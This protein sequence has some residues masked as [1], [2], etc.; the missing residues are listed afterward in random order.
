MRTNHPQAAGGELL[1]GQP[2]QDDAAKILNILDTIYLPKTLLN[3]T[4]MSVNNPR[5]TRLQTGAAMV[6]SYNIYHF[7]I[8][9][10]Y[11]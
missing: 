8:Q 4:H 11:T 10:M 7:Y 9:Y 1:V 6:E 5:A 3:G 2:D